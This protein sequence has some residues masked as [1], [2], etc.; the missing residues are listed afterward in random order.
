M[1]L[2]ETI[3]DK[4]RDNWKILAITFVVLMAIIVLRSGKSGLV[5]PSNLHEAARVPWVLQTKEPD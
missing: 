1:M 3:S 4:L 2:F 5:A